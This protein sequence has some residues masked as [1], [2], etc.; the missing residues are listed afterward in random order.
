[1]IFDRSSQICL[2]MPW[3]RKNNSYHWAFLITF[4]FGYC[5]NLQQ[6]EVDHQKYSH[7]RHEGL[8]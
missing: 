5:V 6:Q 4:K 3:K 2:A 8:E 1:M 7:Q